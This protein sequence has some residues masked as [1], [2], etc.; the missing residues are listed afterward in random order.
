MSAPA[1][2][3]FDA[4]CEMCRR[5]G[6]SLAG[7]ARFQHCQ[8][9]SNQ[10]LS[11]DERHELKLARDDLH[12]FVVYVDADGR[13]RVGAD[14]VVA[15]CNDAALFGPWT[16]WLL[17]QRIVRAA[18]DVTYRVIATRRMF[19]SRALLCSAKLRWRRR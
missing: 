12:R 10:D 8:L 7:D 1:Q 3:F 6:A 9:R 4:E 15:L 13:V 11:D 19:I 18:L 5:I 17:S 2:L 16:R 14:A